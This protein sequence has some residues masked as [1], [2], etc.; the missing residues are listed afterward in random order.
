MNKLA[1]TFLLMLGVCKAFAPVR[2]TSSK[3][4]PLRTISSI[5]DLLGG[6]DKSQLI[7]PEKALP[8]R[9]EKMANIDG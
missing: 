8:G 9:K 1:V 2:A 3:K 5:L 6:P 7:E 4:Q